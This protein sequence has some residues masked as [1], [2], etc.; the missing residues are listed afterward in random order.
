MLKHIYA[1]HEKTLA[2]CLFTFRGE[3]LIYRNLNGFIF[4]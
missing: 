2:E 1:G 4:Y 3:L